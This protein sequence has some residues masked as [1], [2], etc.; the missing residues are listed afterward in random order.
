[1]NTI[2]EQIQEP[3]L[4][5]EIADPMS[6]AG[7]IT[8]GSQTIPHW[9]CALAGPVL[10]FSQ[11]LSSYCASPAHEINREIIE[12]IFSRRSVAR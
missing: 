6:V 10:E 12:Q 4:V 7:A 1:M 9:L 3:E 11:T 2:S 8:D 5:A